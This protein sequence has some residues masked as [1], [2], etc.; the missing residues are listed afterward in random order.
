M[1]PHCGGANQPCLSVFTCV[2][3]LQPSVSASFSAQYAEERPLNIYSEVV[4]ASSD[5]LVAGVASY[6]CVHSLA[7]AAA[8]TLSHSPTHNILLAAT[9]VV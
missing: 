4:V 5:C 8:L 6:G 9:E 1:L 2:M 3:L 7:E